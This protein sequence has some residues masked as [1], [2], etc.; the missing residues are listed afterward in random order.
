MI[1]SKDAAFTDRVPPLDVL[2]WLVRSHCGNLRARPIREFL[3]VQWP[4]VEA[5]LPYHRLIQVYLDRTEAPT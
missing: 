1:V 4:C 3:K 5:P 2:P